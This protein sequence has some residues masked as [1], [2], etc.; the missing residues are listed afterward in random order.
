[1]PTIVAFCGKAG[2]GK[3]TAAQVLCDH[4]GFE[5]L[6]FAD[7]LKEALA[8]IAN[9]PVQNFH[10]PVL[11]E[12][13]CPLFNMTRREALQKFGTESVRDVLGENVW[14][15]RLLRSMSSSGK[16]VISDCR[17]DNEARALREAGG[18]VVRIDR[19][20]DLRDVP[21]HRSEVG[22]SDILIDS[23]INNDSDIDLFRQDV[24]SEVRTLLAG[25]GV[26]L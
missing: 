6:A 9:E 14:V 18:Y 13:F 17:F 21:E 20:S 11:K 16:Y 8:I 24:L 25:Q 10:D 7:P 12:E 3:D 26:K 1:M 23:A 4:L 22:I 15:E 5:R 19:M 2:A